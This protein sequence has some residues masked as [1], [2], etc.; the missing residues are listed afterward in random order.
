[1]CDSR[2]TNDNR[3]QYNNGV[4][5]RCD[6]GKVIAFRKDNQIFVKCRCCK[7]WIAIIDIEKVQ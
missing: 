5:R 7:K 4:P 3:V 6:C 2:L 1:M